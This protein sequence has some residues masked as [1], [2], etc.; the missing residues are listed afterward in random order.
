M[1]QKRVSAAARGFSQRAALL[2]ACLISGAQATT[3]TINSSS[4]AL[5]TMDQICGFR[6]ALDAI[7]SGSAKWGCDA[8]SGTGD[9]INL[10][11]NTY[12]T[13]VGLN[14]TRSVTIRCPAGTCTIDAGSINANL[15]T[16]MGN[17]NPAVSLLKLN[18]RQ[19]SGNTNSISGLVVQTGA[20][21]L[22]ETVVN[23]FK[24]AGL[25]L[26]AG[27]GHTL[28]RSTF[29]NNGYGLSLWSGT[30]VVSQFNTISNNWMGI[31]AA[32]VDLFN[33]YGS[34]I[35]NNADAGI[36]LATSGDILL[37]KTRV[38]GNRNRGIYMYQSSNAIM[39]GCIIERN[40]TPNDGAGIYIADDPNNGGGFAFAQISSTTISNNKAAGNGG[41]LYV[42][43]SATLTNCTLSNDTATRGG[44]SWSI[45]K[46]SN[47]YLQ[48]RHCTIAFNV[49]DSGG[50]IFSVDG[51]GEEMVG[52]FASIVGRNKA[53]KHHPDIS[54][55][56]KSGQ[57]LFGDM[58][59]SPGYQDPLS[60][61]DLTPGD[62]LLGPLMDNA[63]P[64]RVKTHA[65]LK[66]SPAINKADVAGAFT[67]AR[68]FPRSTAQKWD[69][70][71]YEVT[72]FET[73]LLTVISSQGWHAIQTDASL[74]NDAGTVLRSG[75]I[76]DYVTYAV[77]IPE[78]LPPPGLK[79]KIEIGAKT[80]PDGAI[81]QLATAPESNEFTTIGEVDM[82]S[83]TT[84]TAVLPPTS[85]SPL[86]FGFT[87]TGIKYF[88]LKITGRNPANTLGYAAFFDYIRITKL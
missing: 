18:L 53:N 85:S 6:E 77:A 86:T 62:P 25:S 27:T 21:T 12:T 83:S 39:Q 72:P 5:S 34:V 32:A 15:F 45:S 11:A 1:S 33:D 59:G 78:A 40:T 64:N 9:I 23:G 17:N 43:G 60:P 70:G 67:D 10:S 74:N 46:Y 61:P 55:P 63:G 75:A 31:Q 3:Y 22:N 14:L 79:Y 71:A 16:L 81:I 57:S 26:R 69:V 19:S 66:G 68:G 37:E 76:G 28:Y 48:Y 13:P 41:G 80:S 58:T 36:S 20:L 7:N 82:Y 87:Q 56:R 29:S 42:A 8:P 24:V 4:M 44:G 88:R 49:A 2:A 65:L 30:A 47:S 84:R 50:G 52:V 73:E 35:S 51:G 54:G 38:S